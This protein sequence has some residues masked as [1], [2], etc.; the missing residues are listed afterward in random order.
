MGISNRILRNNKTEKNK[1]NKQKLLRQT[2]KTTHY[3]DNSGTRTRN[4]NNNNQN[5]NNSSNNNCI[6]LLLLRP[7]LLLVLC[8]IIVVKPFIG[9]KKLM[10]IT[11]PKDHQFKTTSIIEVKDKADNNS[12][13]NSGSIENE[14]ETKSD[15]DSHNNNRSSS[16]NTTTTTNNNNRQQ[17]VYLIHYHK[18]GHDISVQMRNSIYNIINGMELDLDLDLENNSNDSN[19]SNDDKLRL[20]LRRK[21]RRKKLKSAVEWKRKRNSNN[22]NQKEE[23]DDDDDD[24]KVLSNSTPSKK[25][26]LITTTT[27]NILDA[28]SQ[29]RRHYSKTG[30]SRYNLFDSDNDNDNDNNND[31]YNDNDNDN[32][33]TK[34]SKMITRRL[35]MREERRGR[36]SRGGSSREVKRRREKRIHHDSTTTTQ[37]LRSTNNSNNNTVVPYYK[38]VLYLYPMTAPNFFCALDNENND[39]NI[40]DNGNDNNNESS[41]MQKLK[42]QKQKNDSNT[43]TNTHVKFI[44]MI[45]DPFDMAISYYLYHSQYPTPEPFVKQVK[46]PCLID[47]EVFKFIT[48]IDMTMNIDTMNVMNI[49]ND[50]KKPTTS[51]FSRRP[52]RPPVVA[53][54]QNLLSTILTAKDIHHI[55]QLCY[56][57]MTVPSSNNNNNNSSSSISYYDNFYEA[58][59]NLSEYDGLQ[60]S[61]YYALFGYDKQH[62][63]EGD[64]LRMINNI[65]RLNDY[66]IMLYQQQEVNNIHADDQQYVHTIKMKDWI[67]NYKETAYNAMHFLLKNIDDIDIDKDNSIDD[68]DNSNNNRNRNIKNN[69]TT[70]YFADY[71][72]ETMVQIANITRTSKAQHRTQHKWTTE[73]RNSMIQQLLLPRKLKSISQSKSSLLSD[74]NDN[75]NINDNTSLGL[76]VILQKLQTVFIT[77][78]K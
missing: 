14:N 27:G 63:A 74:N 43:N 32:R 5:S 21:Q 37:L 49:S 66:E 33:T 73:K 72:A 25:F 16:D 36:E 8:I 77:A 48:G 62:K 10:A 67:Q 41:I 9:T 30:C 20:S 31:H 24:D 18:T 34:T 13:S 78:T 59:Q 26:I 76:G 60:L 42:Q 40:N 11:M 68:N 58:L 50:E 29:K 53:P 47:E 1:Q 22:N 51:S 7:I 38:N 71:V 17:Y 75:D 54:L 57:L 4:S 52:R 65:I 69:S 46:D 6:R 15:S 19:D 56:K 3:V 55:Q 12:N 39:S 23:E 45:R 70:D 61:T 28:G 44:H 35:K 2:Q 64:I